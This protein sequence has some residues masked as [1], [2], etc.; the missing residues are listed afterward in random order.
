MKRSESFFGIHFDFHATVESISIGASTTKEMV[1]DVINRVKPDYVQCDCKGHPG[2]SSYPTKVGNAAPQIAGDPLLIWR[3]ATREN[4][5]ALYMHYSG[6]W[7]SEALKHHPEWARMDEHGKLS[8]DITS[9]LGPYVD[10]LLLPQLKELCDVYHVDGVWVDGECWATQRDYSPQVLQLFHEETG[11]TTVPRQ[12]SDA[13]YAEFSAFSRELFLRYLRR[14]VDAI[15]LHQAGFEVASNWA[16]SSFMPE[17][18]SV[19]VDFLSGDFTLQ[20]SINSARIEARCLV[21]QGKPWDL[22]AWGFSGDFNN[23]DFTTKP[24]VQLQQEAAIVL[25]LGGGFQ[26]YYIQK[27]DGSI[28]AWEIEIMEQVA[29]FCRERQHWCHRSKPVPQIAL[30]YSGQGMYRTAESL[31]HPGQSLDGMK[32]IL[33]CLLET[34]QVVDIVMEHQLTGRMDEYPLIIIPEWAYIDPHIHQ[35][36][37]KYA[38]NGCNLLIMGTKTVALFAN[39]IGIELLDAPCKAKHYL[40]FDSMFGVL[41]THFQKVKLSERAIEFASLY[42]SNDNTS[43]VQP[44][45]SI[46]IYGKGRIGAVYCDLGEKYLSANLATMRH[47]MQGI[48]QELFPNP[49][50]QV[51]GSPYVDVTLA[52]NHEHLIVHLVN[53]SGPHAD[54]HIYTFDEITAIGPLHV[55]IQ[56]KHAPQCIQ[57][58]PSGEQLAFEFKDC[59]I[60]LSIPRLEIHGALIISGV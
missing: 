50:V 25:A 9:T 27:P 6:V 60:S 43:P 12:Q 45:A 37:L 18:V 8:P 47:F 21:H 19:D 20:S 33:Q 22:M 7:D 48:V 52:T 39:E 4:G 1:L 44:A 24:A 32:G 23:R 31:F 15:H 11:I 3:E 30:F 14:Y 41:N 40:A 46:S 57:Y 5:V 16:F 29:A 10:E 17:P 55:K 54:K 49:L 38:E 56:A 53:T 34:Q 2:V 58:E 35:E 59:Q 28:N 13:H 42:A 36:L 51:T 26:S